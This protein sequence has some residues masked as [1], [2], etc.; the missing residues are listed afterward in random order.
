MHAWLLVY[1]AQAWRIVYV[2]ESYAS[3][4]RDLK[5]AEAYALMQRAQQVPPPARQVPP[6]AQQVPPPA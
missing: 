1:P 6:P 2:G 3:G 4:S 5:Y